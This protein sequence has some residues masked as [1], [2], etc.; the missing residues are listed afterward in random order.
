M[1]PIHILVSVLVLTLSYT[2]PVRAEK[3]AAPVVPAAKHSVWKVQGAKCSV[4]L[5]GSVH[6]LKAENY[7]LPAVFEN[8]FS[9]ASTVVFETDIGAMML[10]QT[11][12]K[13]M[14]RAQLP[15]GQTLKDLL[16]EKTYAD[17]LA[18]L[19]QSELP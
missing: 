15:P 2:A 13:M 1:K 18:H 9:N 8:A 11:Q 16:S 4:Y 5:L 7:P 10:P 12:A 14:E 6:V 17:L 3:A 19:K